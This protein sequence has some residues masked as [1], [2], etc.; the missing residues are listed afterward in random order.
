MARR[1]VVVVLRQYGRAP[2]GDR[3]AERLLCRGTQH[4]LRTTHRHRRQELAVG[5][6]RHVFGL[7]ADAHIPLDQVVVRHQIVVPERPVGAGAVE[8]VTLQILLAESITLPAPDVGAATH[9]PR[10]ALPTERPVGRRCIRLVVIVHKPVR[11]VLGARIAV[12]LLRARFAQQFTRQVGIR[13]LVRPRVLV[14]FAGVVRT[15]GFHQRHVDTGFG[16][17]FGGP[18]A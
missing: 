16:Q 11:V 17:A 7:S 12:G 18:P 13:Q 10:A 6:L 15:A 8:R 2:D 3:P 4:F 1:P 9:H 5:Q 14:G